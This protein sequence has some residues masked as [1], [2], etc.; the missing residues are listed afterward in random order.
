[1]SEVNRKT[2]LSLYQINF[3]VYL[4]DEA[5]ISGATYKPVPTAP[6]YVLS[7]P[8]DRQLASSELLETYKSS[9]QL[10]LAMKKYFILYIHFFLQFCKL[11]KLKLKKA[12][13]VCL[14]RKQ[15][16]SISQKKEQTTTKI[17]PE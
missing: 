8:S 13:S 10:N 7:T 12:Q 17:K 4:F 9:K 5:K 6:V 15:W 1:M 14:R 3:Q 2:T 16:L 11:P